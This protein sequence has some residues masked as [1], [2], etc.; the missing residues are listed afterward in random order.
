MGKVVFVEVLDRKNSIKERTRIDSLPATIGRGYTNA[1]ILDDRLAD[2]EHLRLS[3]NDEGCILVEDL[4]SVNGTFLP[5]SRERIKQHAIPAGGE[6]ILRIGQTILRLRGDDF[7]VGPVSFLPQARLGKVSTYLENKGIAFLIFFACLGINVLVE[8]Q[9][10]TRNSIWSELLGTFLVMVIVFP[11]W[12]GFWS[13]LGRVLIHSFRFPT[14]LAIAG[15]ATVISILISAGADYAEFLFT[16]PALNGIIQVA[17]NAVLLALLL[18]AH[19][20][21]VSELSAG[22][23]LLPSI[24]I[25]AGLVGIVLLIGYA[26]SSDFSTALPYSS[27]IEPI[28]RPLVRTVPPEEFFSNLDKVQSRVNAMAAEKPKK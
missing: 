3:L 13:F 9:K 16:A 15:L 28:G 17:G 19:L 11:V 24:L 7:A 27:V 6:A 22:K 21:V 23:R 5:K 12:A 25:S 14:H 8:A 18:Y 20:S 26:K 2:S 4:G 1:A 10:I